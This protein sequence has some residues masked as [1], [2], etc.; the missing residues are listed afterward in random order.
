MGK[1][2]DFSARTVI[3]HEPNLELD[4]VGVPRSI[5]MNLTYPK[6]VTPYNIAY[7]QELVH[8]SPT[9]YPGAR[10]VV[11]DT[12]KHID[13]HYN[14]CADTSAQEERGSLGERLAHDELVEFDLFSIRLAFAQ[15]HIVVERL[16]QEHRRQ[17]RRK[18][19]QQNPK[20]RDPVRLHAG[21]SIDISPIQQD[22]VDTRV[23]PIWSI[24][25]NQQT[26]TRAK[27]VFLNRAMQTQGRKLE[28]PEAAWRGA[29][30]IPSMS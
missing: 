14:K 6:R 8:N 20:S 28:V 23:H 4:E 2:V 17:S 11:R 26:Q 21:L 12:G 22:T 7:L 29:R 16:E 30:F 19:Q 1:R 15:H 25:Y 24:K 3:T 10:Y 9:T 18:L 13:L 5:A 27:P